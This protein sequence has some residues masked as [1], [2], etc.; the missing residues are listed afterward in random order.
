MFVK[1]T[2]TP[3]VYG[4][5]FGLRL[6]VTAFGSKR[7]E[8]RITINGKRCDLGLGNAALVSL[9]EA[10]E[11]AIRNKRIARDGGNPLAEKRKQVANGK[12]FK[13]VALSVHQ[14]NAKSYKSDKY[15]AQWLSSLENHVFPQ[16]GHKAISSITSQDILSVLSPIWIDKADTAKKIRQ[17]LSQI[18]TWA[19]AEGY[20][21]SDNPVELAV[22]A[23]PK[24]SSNRWIRMQLSSR[25]F[26]NPSKVR[27]PTAANHATISPAPY[28]KIKSEYQIAPVTPK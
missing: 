17:R 6:I 11:I 7:W 18:M 2:S 21:T 9:E 4:D 25:D 23:L 24:V 8:Q 19:K 14:V 13:E 27:G 1:K 22:L 26:A 3:G 5:G 16:L 10:R 15:A 28:L 20:Y 12:S